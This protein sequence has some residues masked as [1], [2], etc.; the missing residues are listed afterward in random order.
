M[1]GLRRGGQ[2]PPGPAQPAASSTGPPSGAA[3][4]ERWCGSPTPTRSHREA[5]TGSE[6]R[7]PLLLLPPPGVLVRGLLPPRWPSGSLDLGS[8]FTRQAHFPRRQQLPGHPLGKE[9]ETVQGSAPLERS[10]VGPLTPVSS[11][12]P[13]GVIPPL[14]RPCPWAQ[15]LPTP[16]PGDSEPQPMSPQAVQPSG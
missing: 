13:W 12:S 2:G 11:L 14:Q 8:G 5:G 10:L 3:G 7:L 6:P 16:T 1:G 15:G 9:G 4:A